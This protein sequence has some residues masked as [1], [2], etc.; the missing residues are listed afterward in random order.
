M[1]AKSEQILPFAF[2]EQHLKSS[3]VQYLLIL[4]DAYK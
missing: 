1:Q 3:I 4:Q 2:E